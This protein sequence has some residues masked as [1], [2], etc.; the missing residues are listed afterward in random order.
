MR[1]PTPEMEKTADK[2]QQKARGGETII[3]RRELRVGYYIKILIIVAT[4][5]ACT[6]Y[7]DTS[8]CGYDIMKW[9]VLSL[10]QR[11]TLQVT[12]MECLSNST[13]ASFL[14][15]LR[16][17][18]CPH[19]WCV[20]LASL[21]ATHSCSQT[22]RMLRLWCVCTLWIPLILSLP[23]SPSPPFPSPSPFLS[24]SLPLLLSLS[25][26]CTGFQMH[27]CSKWPHKHP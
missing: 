19:I 25:L 1:V 8:E 22:A 4:S 13:S 14:D 7:N 20:Q 5:H 17:V 15:V 6:I 26:S 11:L 10:P 9:T 12:L 2:Q 27:T 3:A 24:L 18:M 21:A 16:Y 23:L